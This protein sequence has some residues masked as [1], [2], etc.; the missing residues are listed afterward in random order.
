MI[1]N[2]VVSI[3]MRK[4]VSFVRAWREHL[5]LTQREV[6]ERMG[7]SQ[8]SYAQMESNAHKLRPST[9]K[10]IA[11]AFGIE[12]EQLREDDMEPLEDLEE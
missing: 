7:I 11:D 12:W 8:S 2:E 9:A 1:P 3:L 6:A 4:R 10:R 5:G